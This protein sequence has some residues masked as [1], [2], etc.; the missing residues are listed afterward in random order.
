MIDRSKNFLKIDERGV[1][2]PRSK[3]WDPSELFSNL[4][5][6]TDHKM[7]KLSYFQPLHIHKILHQQIMF[8]QTEFKYGA[9]NY[10]FSIS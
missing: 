7:M 2:I 4:C 5:Q 6:L 3:A 1:E 10:N 8:I 9:K